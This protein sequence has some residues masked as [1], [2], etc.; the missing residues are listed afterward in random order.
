MQAMINQF[1]N[2]ANAWL[3]PFMCGA[4]IVGIGF[5]ACLYFLKKSQLKFAKH[6]EKKIYMY[7]IEGERKHEGVEKHKENFPA[8][9]RELVNV[10]YNELYEM[11][12]EKMRRKLD[13]VT[14]MTDRMF[15]LLEGAKRLNH[16]LAIQ[17]RYHRT[18]ETQP[19]F[20]EITN[21]V[22]TTNPAY[23]RLFGIFSNRSLSSCISLLP[24]LFVIGGIFGTFVGIMQGLPELSNMDLTSPELTKKTMDAFL[25]NIAYSMNTSLVGIALCVMMNVLNT[26]F[27]SEDLDEEFSEK[28][29]SCLV[30]TWKE[31]MM[32]RHQVPDAP[33]MMIEGDEPPPL[34]VAV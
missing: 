27:D 21:Y 5:R 28:I 23:S 2:L 7:L 11:K 20:E 15:L 14:T 31:S 24:G 6:I 30:L 29:K 16:D 34:K 9:T 22:T 32:A 17:L 10:S 1:L 19:N 25:I 18:E 26:I 13:Y 12:I 3:I 33:V 8:L 4:F